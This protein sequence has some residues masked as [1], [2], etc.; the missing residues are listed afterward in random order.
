MKTRIV[1]AI[2]RKDALDLGLS[3]ASILAL[4]TAS[5]LVLR[6]RA[7]AAASS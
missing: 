3:L 2:A 4:L 7:G 6:R 1:L 5:F